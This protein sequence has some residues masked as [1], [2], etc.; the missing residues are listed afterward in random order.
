MALSGLRFRVLWIGSSGGFDILKYNVE[1]TYGKD[2][3]WRKEWPI[4]L[5]T[6]NQKAKGW[7]DF[8]LETSSGFVIID[9]KSFPGSPDQCAAKDI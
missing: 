3:V 7:I 5:K 1:Q 9:H 8:L 4:H 6:K 2:C